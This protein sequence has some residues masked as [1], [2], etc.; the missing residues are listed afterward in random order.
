M[1]NNNWQV[2]HHPADGALPNALPFRSGIQLSN[3]QDF[4]LKGSFPPLSAR[5]LELKCTPVFTDRDQQP[6]DRL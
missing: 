2:M 4:P 5:R 1:K 6:Y 3:L